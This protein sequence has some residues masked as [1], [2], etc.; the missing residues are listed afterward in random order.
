L[1]TKIKSKYI[2]AY[3]AGSHSILHNGEVVIEGQ[4]I[5]YAGPHYEG[6][7]DK[8]I[9]A[10]DKIVSPGLINMHTLT[11]T[12][13]TYLTLDG[14]SEG[15]EINGDYVH[16]KKADMD[17]QDDE[18]ELS[19]R[20]ALIGAVKGGA[21]TVVPI[22]PMAYSLWESPP[23]QAEITARVAGTLGVRAYVSHQYRSM[24]KYKEPSGQ[25][26]YELNE[27]EGRDGLQRAFDFCKTH[28]GTYDR[29]I[30][31]MLFPYQFETCTPGLLQATKKLSEE[32]GIPIHMHAAE[33]TNQFHE[34]LRRYGKTPVKAM[35]DIGIMGPR[36]ILTHI[37]HTSYNPMSGRPNNDTSDIELLAESGTTVVRCPVLYSRGFAGRAGLHPFSVFSDLGVNMTLGTDTYPMDMLRE[38]RQAAILGKAADGAKIRPTAAEIFNAVTLNAAKALNRDDLGR[39]SAGAKAD[40]II[41]DPHKIELAQ[42]DDPV[43]SIVYMAS[44][45]DIDTVIIDGK[46]IVKEST[47]QGV[48][49]A[50]LFEDIQKINQRQKKTFVKYNPSGKSETELFPPSFPRYEDLK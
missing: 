20:F 11:S 19:S 27:K 28:E 42:M 2:I 24:V 14:S 31:T 25:T 37:L 47:F 49:E 50:G 44:Q 6:T 33:F 36:T 16:N 4:N 46:T 35:Y 1:K 32:H 8:T 39:I 15:L 18:I 21:T 40:L 3:K 43:K 34:S 5:I 17:L 10:G 7:V 30:R 29:R 22:T 26:R 38:M 41:I 45:A 9:D 12:S 13:V 23:T 48:D